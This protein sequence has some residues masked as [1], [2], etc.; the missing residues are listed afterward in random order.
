MISVTE[1]LDLVVQHAGRQRT[2]T[3]TLP[4]SVGLTLAEDVKADADSP[5]FDKS[6]MDGFA[7]RASDL[8]SKKP[9][10]VLG[11]FRAGHLA[12]I[13]VNEG[14]CVAIMTGAP[15]PPGTDAVV[16]VERC[17]VEAG[18][19]TCDL[20]SIKL[21]ANILKR[22]EEFKAGEV[23]L[24]RGRLLGPAEMGLLATV[25]EVVPR[26]HQRA[27][28]GI[29]AT[30]DELVAA[31][32]KPQA[33]QIRNSNTATLDALLTSVRAVPVDLGIAP[34]KPEQI[35]RLI[36]EGLEN[37]LLVITGGVSM[38]TADYI[39]QTLAKLGVK[40]VFHKVA[41]KPGKPVWF[42]THER[43]LVFGL[44]GN[45]VSVLA[46]FELFVTT[47]LKARQGWS[48]PLPP[49]LNAKLAADFHYATNRETYHPAT[50]VF[51]DGG[52]VV[53][54]VPW[55]GSA[56]VLGASAADALAVLP[57]G[58]GIHRANDRLRVLPLSKPGW[59]WQCSGGGAAS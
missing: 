5:P 53:T 44:P 55:F 40:E 56:D 12:V 37:D 46:C 11:E 26:V 14:E 35:E 17:R 39:P 57:V 36:K 20:D 42:G 9:L 50:L 8:N 4:E 47:A 41:M 30:G 52:P 19:M 23:L 21:G 34:D 16:M 18:E 10:R 33:G 2:Q 15:I 54:P 22:G 51:S 25:G 43:G 31:K 32:A 3:E 7:V 24:Q 48:D 45:P 6:M 38:G 13:Q 27:T 59:V 49:F 1:A 58:P 29:L 28:A